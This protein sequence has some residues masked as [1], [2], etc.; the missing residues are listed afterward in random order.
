VTR[1]HVVHPQRGPSAATMMIAAI[2]LVASMVM[3]RANDSV[4]SLVVFSIAPGILLFFGARAWM[5]R[6]TFIA[7]DR[8]GELRIVWSAEKTATLELAKVSDVVLEKR[9]PSARSRTVRIVVV[10]GEERF[11]LTESF[12]GGNYDAK[13]A[14]LKSFLRLA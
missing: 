6:V 2:V 3:L 7:D 4:G 10:A 9:H 5:K 11:P 8:R 1:T 12:I 13:V 14:E